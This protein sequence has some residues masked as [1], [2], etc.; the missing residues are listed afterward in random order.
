MCFFN[1]KQKKVNFLFHT[2]P[3]SL[4]GLKNGG[5]EDLVSPMKK[6]SRCAV[7]N[8]LTVWA[9]HLFSAAVRVREAGNE[10]CLVSSA[11]MLECAPVRPVRWW[12]WTYWFSFFCHLFSFIHADYSWYFWPVIYPF[13]QQKYIH[14]SRIMQ[15]SS[16]TLRGFSFPF[17]KRAEIV[18]ANLSPL[19][20]IV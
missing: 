15:H 20:G 9:T 6:R 7:A 2:S 12:Y 8:I 3:K 14:F 4:F 5:E 11:L 16:K 10:L 18:E 1:M 19:T 13:R 17:S